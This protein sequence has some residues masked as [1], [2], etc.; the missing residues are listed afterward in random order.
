MK[1]HFITAICI[2]A[3]LVA[4]CAKAVQTSPNESE[5]RRVESWVKYQQT[6]HPE[7]LW[8]Q[9]SLGCYI[10]EE[11]EGT[12]AL[13]GY[14]S[15]NPYAYITYSITDLDG[16]ILDA[17]DEATAHQLGTYQR[18]NF[19]GP[20]VLARGVGNA[21]A[22]EDE[23]VQ[24]MRVGGKRKVLVPGWLMTT[25]RYKD[26]NGYKNTASE[27]SSII[28]SVEVKDIFPNVFEWQVDS[29]ET[30][31]KR[32]YPKASLDT[33]EKYGFYFYQLTPPEDPDEIVN[34]SDKFY[35]NY[36]GMLL[37]GT[38]FDSTYEEVCKDNGLNRSSYGPTYVTH[39]ESYDMSTMGDSESNIIDGF[40]FAAYKMKHGESAIAVFYS[41]WG[42][43]ESGS[44]KTIPPYSPL[45]FKL[46]FLTK[47]EQQKIIDAQ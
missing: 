29:I 47:E 5:I 40:A 20:T 12:G 25:N 39:G 38:I 26:A 45:L 35:L 46:D 34:T 10:L 6:L 3:A 36:T 7:Y 43:K 22:G 41:P 33:S 16:N 13:I 8:T 32:N 4:S 44:G 42:Y 19:Y 27:V 2:T 23:I 21:Y 15:D 1:N 28:Y 14:P 37:N 9:T 31:L 30:F 17:S 11:E 24:G 18:Q